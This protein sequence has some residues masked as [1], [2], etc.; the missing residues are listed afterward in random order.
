MS[1]DPDD[2]ASIFWTLVCMCSMGLWWD[3]IKTKY[4]NNNDDDEDNDDLQG[5]IV[6]NTLFGFNDALFFAY[7]IESDIKTKWTLSKMR[8]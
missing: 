8:V 5:R 7:L 6:H 2:E 1:D 3:L 4:N